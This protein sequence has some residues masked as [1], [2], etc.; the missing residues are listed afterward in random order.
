MNEVLIDVY[1]VNAVINVNVSFVFAS[2]VPLQAGPP[3]TSIS[4]P[5]T[6]YCVIDTLG[7]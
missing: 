7:K 2:N 5:D 1:G 6:K 4:V 3:T